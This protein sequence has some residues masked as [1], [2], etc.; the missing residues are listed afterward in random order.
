MMAHGISVLLIATA[1][2]YWTLTNANKEKGRVKKLGQ[3]LGLL[4]IVISLL[5]TFCKIACAVKACQMG[6]GAACGTMLGGGMGGGKACPFGSKSG[7]P[8]GM[9]GMG[10]CPAG[11]PGCTM[12]CPVSTG[13]ESKQE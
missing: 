7:A 11:H 4:I 3:F 13:T 10:A 8:H 9:M 2:G 5:G 1:V 12:A 6:K